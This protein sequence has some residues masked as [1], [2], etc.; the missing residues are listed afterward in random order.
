[1]PT[2]PGVCVPCAAILEDVD[3]E[4]L[5]LWEGRD[6]LAIRAVA[7]KTI[8]RGCGAARSGRFRGGVRQHAV[9]QVNHSV[10]DEKV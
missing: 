4:L 6:K 3:C 7:T 10:V 5:E 8:L 9:K 1:M 2:C